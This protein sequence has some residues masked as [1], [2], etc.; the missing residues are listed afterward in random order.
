AWNYTDEL[1]L[2]IGAFDLVELDKAN[3]LHRINTY[4]ALAFENEKN[5][6]EV[7]ENYFTNTEKAILAKVIFNQE[8]AV[9][10]PLLVRGDNSEHA[11]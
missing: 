9:E 6:I 8:P 7:R 5:I 3:S 11:E 4:E 1:L 10:Q 2:I